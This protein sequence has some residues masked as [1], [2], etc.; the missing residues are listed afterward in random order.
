MIFNSKAVKGMLVLLSLFAADGTAA[1]EYCEYD[2]NKVELGDFVFVSDPV[3]EN[4]YRETAN[5]NGEDPEGIEKMIRYH[6]GLG[7]SLR[8]QRIFVPVSSDNETSGSV[9]HQ[10]SVGLVLSG[11]YRDYYESVQTINTQSREY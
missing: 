7:F 6:D 4:T 11:P 5:E 10:T 2:N 3:L 1:K 9:L 8:C